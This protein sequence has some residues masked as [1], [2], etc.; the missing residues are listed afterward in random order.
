MKSP[1]VRLTM[2]MKLSFVTAVLVLVAVAGCARQHTT[3]PPAS[4][5]SERPYPYRKPLTSLGA[6]F[7]A[8]PPAVRNTVR[9]E[10]GM[11]EIAEVSKSSTGDR[12]YY[13]IDFKDPVNF[14]PLFV[15][16][17]GSV[18]NPDLTVAVPAPH[19]ASGGLAGGP[20]ESVTVQDLPTN[21]LALVETRAPAADVAAVSKETW[22][23]HVVYRVSFKDQEHLPQMAISSE[24][25]V[26]HQA[27]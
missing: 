20:A 3:V 23:D 26:L 25:T 17:D 14:P 5:I 2:V 16:A 22:G 11:Q 4:A 27:K 21:V 1:P 18:L 10:A 9:A 24:G 7:G 12:V 13:K 19:D 8:L 6:K 15:A